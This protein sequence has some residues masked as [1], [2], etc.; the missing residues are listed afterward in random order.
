MADF[1]SDADRAHIDRLLGDIERDPIGYTRFAERRSAI[2]QLLQFGATADEARLDAMRNRV[3]LPY[4][5]PLRAAASRAA[6]AAGIC[7]EVESDSLHLQDRLP[8]LCYGLGATH[9]DSFNAEVAACLRRFASVVDSLA[10]AGF[11]VAAPP[12]TV[13]RETGIVSQRLIVAIAML[14]RVAA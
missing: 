4:L 9:A 2:H 1:L 8:P 10:H 5:N 12:A 3:G 6:R 7:Y 11:A 14:E 13:D